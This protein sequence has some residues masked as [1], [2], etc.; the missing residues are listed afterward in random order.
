MLKTSKL[1]S[2][3]KW[4]KSKKKEKTVHDRR[5]KREKSN[6]MRDLRESIDSRRG[7]FISKRPSLPDLSNY[8]SIKKKEKPSEID[9]KG[10]YLSSSTSEESTEDKE[11]KRLMF[12]LEPNLSSPRPLASS[13]RS[14]SSSVESDENISIFLERIGSWNT[15]EGFDLETK[16]SLWKIRNS[17][18][19]LLS[20]EALKDYDR[21]TIEKSSVTYSL[22]Q[23]TKLLC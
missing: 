21:V 19:G 1:L 13:T 2:P 5:I 23:T 3:R 7:K 6:S 18:L 10:F 16:L 15:T 20:L 22:I 4:K 8:S 11:C 12:S 17:D 9:E 14:E